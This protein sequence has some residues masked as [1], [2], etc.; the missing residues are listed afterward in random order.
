MRIATKI[1]IIKKNQ[2]EI[3]ELKNTITELKTSQEGLNRL[4]H[5][6]ERIKKLEDR[7]FEVIEFEDQKEK[8][9]KKSKQSL[10]D[11]WEIIKQEIIHI[12]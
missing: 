5:E 8:G 10:R 9:M 12:I 6:E 2:A 1:E 3:P 4:K 7:S 11:L